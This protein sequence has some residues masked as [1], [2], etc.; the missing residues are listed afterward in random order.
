MSLFAIDRTKCL[1]DGLCADEC[2]RYLIELGQDGDGF[3]TPGA[4]ADADCINCGH[5]LAVCPTGALTLASMPGAQCVEV[6]PALLPSAEQ[7]E[8]MLRTRR[9]IRTYTDQPVPRALLARLLDV[10]RYAPTGSNRQNVQ[11]L[12]IYDTALVR[13]VASMTL[14][15]L[16]Q[17]AGLS[18]YARTYVMAAEKGLDLT[19]RAAPHMALALVPKGQETNGV[20]ALTHLELAADALG[21]GACWSGLANGPINAS[22]A[23]RELLGIPE[24]YV[25]AGAMLLGYARYAYPRV[26]LR[27]E[28]HV[29]WR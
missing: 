12:M 8:H 6:N 23:L 7:V 18:S 26:P 17:Q 9:S 3:P 27:N 2:P 19:C 10:V 29:T 25:S 5:C 20:I 28:G 13:R 1:R 16:R 14:D 15:L 21:L 24:G 4:N 22:P 11:W